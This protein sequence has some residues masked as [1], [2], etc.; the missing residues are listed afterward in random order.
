MK[1]T[2]DVIEDLL[3]LYAE[4]LTSDDTNFLVEEH[5]KTCTDCKKQLEAIQYPKEMPINTD[6]DPFKKVEKKLFHKRVQIITLTIVLV[7]AIVIITMAYLTSPEYLPY[8]NETLSIKDDED[9]KIIINFDDNV[10]GYDIESHKL[11]NNRGYVYHITTWNNIWNQYIFKNKAQSIILN[12]DDEDV[13]SIYYYSTDGSGDRLIYGVNL[14]GNGGVLTLP[15]LALAYYLI[16]AMALATVFGILLYVYR[17][18]GKEKTILERVFILP[19]S[20]II[21]H[22]CIKGFETTSYSMQRDFF[23]I[24]LLMIPIYCLLFLV[25]NLYGKTKNKRNTIYK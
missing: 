3:P 6:I 18:K 19:V 20:Y 15:R 24:L 9:G 22:F 11:E 4:G 5:L 12:P 8:S 23:A 7:L 17:E 25:T 21:A 1:I 14:L 10:A 16:L 2:C 13:I